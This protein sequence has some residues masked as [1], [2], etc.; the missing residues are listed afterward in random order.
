MLTIKALNGAFWCNLE[1]KLGCLKAIFTPVLVYATQ[2][3]MRICRR[4]GGGGG[5]W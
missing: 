2:H 4:G 5:G 3:I 1:V